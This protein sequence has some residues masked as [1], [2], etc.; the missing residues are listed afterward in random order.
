MNMRVIWRETDIIQ[1]QD[2]S[3]KILNFVAQWQVH[4]SGLLKYW[5]VLNVMFNSMINIFLGFFGYYLISYMFTASHI[6]R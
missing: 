2:Y 5:K 4:K 3:P 1:P 6:G